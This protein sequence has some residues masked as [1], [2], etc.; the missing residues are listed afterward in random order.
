[1]LAARHV[2]A[3]HG[4]VGRLAQRA[5]PPRPARPGRGRR[6]SP[7][8]VG[9]AGR[10][11]PV[12]LAVGRAPRPTVRRAPARRAAASASEPL[13]PAPPSTATVSPAWTTLLVGAGAPHTSSTARR[14]LGG[15]VF[16]KLRHDRPGEQDRVRP[17]AGTCS[18]PPSQPLRPSVIRSGV[19]VSE[20]SV[21]TRSPTARC[22]GSGGQPPRR[23][24]SASRRNRSPG[25][26][27][28][29]VLHDAEHLGAHRITVAGVLLPQLSVAGRVEI[30]L[31]PESA[32][33]SARFRRRL[34]H[35]TA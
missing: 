34:P 12:G 17:S 10:P 32:P 2:D 23:H 14:A 26:H 20:T 3:D 13:L 21:A 27:L 9:E 16:G 4:D 5:G 24:R 30:E 6:R 22:R 33:R 11:Q 8:V 31:P 29:T 19:S 25:W 18:L 7:T 15:K 1:M 35:A 28:A